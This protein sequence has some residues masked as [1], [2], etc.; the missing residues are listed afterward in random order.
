MQ[1]GDLWALGLGGLLALSGLVKFM[2]EKKFYDSSVTAYQYGF[3]YVFFIAGLVAILAAVLFQLAEAEPEEA[4]A[5]S[6]EKA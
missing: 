2:L 4:E 6:E 5:E 3:G 1:S